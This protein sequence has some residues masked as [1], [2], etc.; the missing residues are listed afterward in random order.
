MEDIEQKRWIDPTLYA[1]GVQHVA[2]EPIM[3]CLD[4]GYGQPKIITISLA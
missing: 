2:K 1:T 3:A 4:L